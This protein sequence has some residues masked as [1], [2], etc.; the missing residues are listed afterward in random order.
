MI[1]V[2]RR[3]FLIVQYNGPTN[4]RHITKR[5]QTKVINFRFLFIKLTNPTID[6][7]CD[8]KPDTQST[9]CCADGTY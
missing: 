9:S 7:K 2:I 8:A 1:K 3:A 6:C 5:K 4:G